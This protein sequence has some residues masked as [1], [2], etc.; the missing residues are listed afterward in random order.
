MRLRKWDAYRVYLILSGL[1]S[2]FFML[3]F[4]LNLVYEAQVV[5]LTPLQLVLVGTTVETTCFLFEIPTGIVADLYSRRLSVI[6]GFLLIGIGFTIEGAFPFFGAVLLNQ[7][8]WGIGSTF[9]SGALDAW[10]IDEVG[11]ARMGVVLLRGSQAGQIG[12]V[13]GVIV[14]VILGS[15]ALALPVVVGGLLFVAL[16]V[17]LVFVMPET[18]FHPTPRGE[19]STWQSMRHTLTES[20]RLIRLRPTLLTLAAVTLVLGLYSEGYDR[21]WQAH[22]LRDFTLPAL[23]SLSPVVWFGI[24]NIVTM[25]LAALANEIVR[26]R[27]NMNQQR[28]L[29]AVLIAAHAAMV[30]AL[31][32]LALAVNLWLALIGLLIM[33]TLRSTSAPILS[34]WT[35]Q[36]IDSNVRA[37]MLSSFGQLNAVGQIGGGPFVGAIGD[38]WGLRAALSVAAIL[39]SPVIWL[40]A[41]GSRQVVAADAEVVTAE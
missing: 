17:F 41:R 11:E 12:G 16:T 40:I 1:S 2:L 37:T 22:L 31:L 25:L 9:T 38:R 35:N 3:I 26:R 21:L 33:G 18:N 32:I 27:L 4:T 20:I 8:I 34:T 23:D 29:A 6:I 19:R 39:L 7:V 28:A 15:V 13:A 10:I 5:G 14:S 24:I 36:H 30:A